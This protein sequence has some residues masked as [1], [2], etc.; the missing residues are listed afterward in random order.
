MV[1]LKDILDQIY[2]AASLIGAEAEVRPKI[3]R[4]LNTDATALALR[5]SWAELRKT[6]TLTW[7][8]SEILMP[9]DM[10]GIDL[11]WDDLYE[12]V[13]QDRNRADARQ[14]EHAF[15]YYT[16]P[17]GESLIEVSDAALSQDVGTLASDTLTASGLDMVGEYFVV[18]GEEQHYEITA[19]E[20]G[21]YS[22]T[23]AYRGS[24][25]RSA[26][27]VTVR[28]KRTRYLTLVPPSYTQVPTSSFTVDYW[29]YPQMLRVD[30]DIVPFPTMDVLLYRTLSKMPE[31]RTKRPI[32]PTQVEAAFVQAAALNED[33]PK[34]RLSTGIQGTPLNFSNH[35]AVR[36]GESRSLG[37]GLGM[38]TRWQQNRI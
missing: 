5:E 9:A 18:A 37:G 1:I 27:T 20:S 3:L 15:R 38:V 36:G 32:S 34:P 33:R 28:P 17:A 13:Y 26:A 2:I 23:P 6:V 30:S 31:S 25:T 24:G 8:G 35:Y 16:R 14:V 7:T 21:L 11:V 19:V 12:V 29:A 22:F 4:M 10:V